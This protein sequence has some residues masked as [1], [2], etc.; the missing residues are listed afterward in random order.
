MKTVMFICVCVS[1]HLLSTSVA[2]PLLHICRCCVCT[3]GGRLLRFCASGSVDFIW[4]FIC[5]IAWHFTSIFLIFINM[6]THTY[7]YTWPSLFMFTPKSQRVAASWSFVSLQRLPRLSRSSL[8]LVFTWSAI[9]QYDYL[10]LLKLGIFSALQAS[11]L[12]HYKA[13]YLGQ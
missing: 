7:I 10:S 3:A 5:L 8:L 13:T 2:L 9:W 11:F 6:H 12:F 1:V 4:R